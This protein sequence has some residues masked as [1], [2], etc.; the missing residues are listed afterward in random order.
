MI[1]GLMI[2]RGQKSG[3]IKKEKILLIEQRRKK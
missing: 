2:I 1:D 3:S